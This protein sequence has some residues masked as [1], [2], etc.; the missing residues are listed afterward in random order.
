VAA[1]WAGYAVENSHGVPASI[2]LLGVVAEAIIGSG[3]VLA[4]HLGCGKLMS[5]AGL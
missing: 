3:A 1:G 2:A 4:I 5:L